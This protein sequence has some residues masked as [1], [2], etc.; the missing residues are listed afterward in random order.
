[1]KRRK[2]VGPLADVLT[3]RDGKLP[4]PLGKC[5]KVAGPGLKMATERA[6]DKLKES[7][8]EARAERDYLKAT[9][10]R[11]RMDLDKG[12]EDQILLR[13]PR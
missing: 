12:E 2:G 1:M 10:T 9:L 13:S 7:N 4:G 3:G 11:F 6:A 8:A 5:L